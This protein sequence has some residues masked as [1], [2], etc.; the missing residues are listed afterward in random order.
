M[1]QRLQASGQTSSSLLQ[2][3]QSQR[4]VP[5]TSSSLQIDIKNCDCL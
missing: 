5:E 2:L 3:Y 1:Q 4:A